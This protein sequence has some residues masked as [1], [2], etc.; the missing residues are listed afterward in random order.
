MV[1]HYYSN[2]IDLTT[3]VFNDE[4]RFVLGDDKRWVWRKYGERNIT[5]TAA[6]QKFPESIMI[7]GAIS[8]DYKSNLVIVDG[9]IDSSKY[10]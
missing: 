4:S 2:T 5:A 9:N 7:Y 6:T 8:K 1:L 3:I 10:Q